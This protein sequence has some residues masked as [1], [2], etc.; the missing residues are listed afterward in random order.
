M[1]QLHGSHKSESIAGGAGPQADYLLPQ[2]QP[3]KPLTLYFL[4][5]SLQL[6]T[7]LRALLGE[8][9]EGQHARAPTHCRSV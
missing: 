3:E 4:T 9:F 8:D 7:G 2:P 5:I 6:F 1:Q